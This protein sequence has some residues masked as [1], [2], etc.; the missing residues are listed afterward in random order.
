[1]S[2]S[3]PPAHKV[4]VIGTGARGR[5]L[6]KWLRM[7]H[8]AEAAKLSRTLRGA[9]S[10]IEY[11]SEVVAVADTDAGSRENARSVV[12]SDCPIH[13][14]PRR[15]L[16]DPHVEVVCI[17]TTS[18]VHADWAVAAM[19]A[20]KAVICE[21]PMTTTLADADRIC[22]AQ[23]RT[24]RFFGLSMQN[25]YSFWAETMTKLMRNRELGD[26]TMLWCHEFRCPFWPKIGNWITDM[27]RSGGPFLEKNSH[28]WDIFN[29]WTQAPAKTVHALTATTGFNSS[30]DIWDCG[31]TNV[32]YANGVIAN[33]GL[34][35]MTR[36]GHLLTMG[37]I[38]TEGWAE[39][40][41]THDGGTVEYHDNQSP[42]TR[43]YRAEMP[44]SLQIGHAG[45]ETPMFN[46]LFDCIEKGIEPNTSCWWGRESIIL[47]LA[48]QRSADERRAVEV[49]E[50][51]AESLFPE[52]TPE[53]RER[54]FG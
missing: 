26:V 38:G 9:P 50:I 24:G 12:A 27:E 22:E 20:G 47:G 23:R 41:R 51:R 11:R 42:Q 29:W 46:H 48:A 39:A 21:K 18:I 16:D 37:A 33:H 52:A 25:R 31:W 17:A 54:P 14:D 45:A 43:T 10:P 36:F 2:Q 44:A 53:Y 34:S 32:E 7:G 1:M 13:D 5:G 3:E 4:G 40:E 19:E 30:G 15:V 49:D 6:I 28:H 35:L 8:P